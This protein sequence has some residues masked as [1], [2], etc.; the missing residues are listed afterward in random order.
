MLKHRKILEFLLFIVIVLSGCQ[1]RALVD[2]VNLHY[3][4]VYFNQQIQNTTYGFYDEEYIKPTFKT[5]SIMRFMLCESASGSVISERFLTD[6]GEDEKGRY[7]EG[8]ITCP[9]G[10]YQ[11]LAYNWDTELT[12]VKAQNNCKTVSAYTEMHSKKV[13]TVFKSPDLLFVAK[14]RIVVNKKNKVDTLYGVNSKKFD[15][16]SI[17]ESYF[18]KIPIRGLTNMRELNAVVTGFSPEEQLLDNLRTD[19]QVGIYTTMKMGKEVEEDVYEFYTT[20]NTFAH[21]PG[22]ISKLHIIFYLSLENGNMYSLDV[23]ITEKFNS[24]DVLEH[25]WIII[26]TVYDAPEGVGGGG[27]SP[28]V[29]QWETVSSDVYI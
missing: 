5:P 17:V 19:E 1:H 12:R 24:P 10:Q 3:V 15:A 21:V 13:D 7:I 27:F 16:S 23:D 28:G 2:P 18:L 8:Y 26:D 25:N 11:M 9:P 6:I 20:F 4:K 29:S 22:A 14:D